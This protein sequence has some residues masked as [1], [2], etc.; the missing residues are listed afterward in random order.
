MKDLGLDS[1]AELM[2]KVAME[3]TAAFGEIMRRYQSPLFNFIYRTLSDYGEAEDLTQET[4]LRIYN[5]AKRYKPSAKFTTYLFKIARNLCLNKLRKSHRFNIFSLEEKDAG[6]Q[7][8]DGNSPEAIYEKKET[9]ALIGRALAT[10]PE[11]QRMAVILQRF[12]N[13]SY[14]EISK[15]MGCS[16]SAVESLLF[17]AK[18]NLKTKLSASF[19]D[20]ECL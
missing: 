16:V 10:L 20:N 2:D 13:L 1:D 19:L 6:I 17:R 18:Q 7:A 4:F 12:H 11:N 14:K 5:S 8:P 3:D 9:A 15:V